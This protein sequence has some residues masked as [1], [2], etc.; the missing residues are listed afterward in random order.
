MEEV[1]QARLWAI[2]VSKRRMT[3][4]ATY[5]TVSSLRRPCV[6]PATQQRRCDSNFEGIR[7]PIA[8]GVS[9]L[10]VGVMRSLLELKT[11]SH[12]ALIAGIENTSADISNKREMSCTGS[13]ISDS[14]GP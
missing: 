1:L 12:S 14:W 2:A 5:L 3:L 7:R 10:R 13:L 9:L 8:C 11:R 6:E 4:L